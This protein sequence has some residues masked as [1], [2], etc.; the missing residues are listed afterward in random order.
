M[1]LS[2]DIKA[3]ALDLGRIGGSQARQ[4]LEASLA[5]EADELARREIQDALNNA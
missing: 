4:I 5:R 2:E 1:S 3:S